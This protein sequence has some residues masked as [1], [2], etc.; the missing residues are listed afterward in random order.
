M[1]AMFRHAASAA[2][3]TS[4]WDVSSVIDMS[5]MFLGA[6]SA[7]PDTSYWDV[8]SATTMKRMFYQSSSAD[9]DTSK[10]A[11]GGMW[12][13]DDALSGVYLQSVDT[14]GIFLGM[15]KANHFRGPVLSKS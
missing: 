3:E 8:S 14:E 2:P 10:W 5:E 1:T 9:P 12:E 7:S 13:K 6:T 15:C 4:G 11:L